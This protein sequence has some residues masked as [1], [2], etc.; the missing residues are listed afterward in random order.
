MYHFE[1][2]YPLLFRQRELFNNLASERRLRHR[3]IRNK[4][5]PMNKF[6]TGDLVVARKHVKSSRKDRIAQKLLFKTKGL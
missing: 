4:G 1:A 3:D 6:D 5:K 2:E